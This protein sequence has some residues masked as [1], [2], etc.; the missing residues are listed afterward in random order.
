MSEPRAD[1][2]PRQQPPPGATPPRA[3]N[4]AEGAERHWRSGLTPVTFVLSLLVA[5]FL[6]QVQLM[7]VLLILAIV[8][9][10]LIERPVELLQSRH[11]P[12]PLSILIMY[13]AI[14]AGLGLFFVGVAPAIREQGVIFREE[15][16]AQIQSLQEGWAVSPNPLLNGVGQDALVRV[17]QFI[18][19][20][21]TEISVPEGAAD[22][23]LSLATGVGGGVIGLLTTLVIAFYYLMEK[24][25]LRQIILDQLKPGARGRIAQIFDNVE[26]KVGDWMRGQLV[27]MLVIGVSATIGYGILGVRFWPLLGIW[28]GLTEIIPIVGPWLGGIPAVI[29]ALTQGWDKALV[30]I[31]FIV[32]LQSFE[33]YILVPR[34]MRGAVGLSP[35]TVFLAI[36]AGT[37]FLGILGAVLAIP[38]AAAVQVV[39]SDYFRSRREE[40][41][42]ETPAALTSWQ[43]MR[44]PRIAGAEGPGM[45][46]MADEPAAPSRR[47]QRTP[48]TQA[49]R[50]NWNRNV[51]SRPAKPDAEE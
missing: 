48:R 19:A 13:I 9:A 21:G 4:G 45:A 17:I 37:Q 15:A 40:Y 44:G 35:M 1:R 33:N 5:Y 22:M 8:F 20:P 42:A 30:V 28:A 34:V 16:P 51:L 39:L 29:I 46:L 12:R 38:I 3:G 7:L 49:K 26:T 36:L 11:L 47:E 27:L 25:W 43:W 23:V 2:H 31:G 10:T 32:L 50:R 6:L 14:I 24:D 41:L 18:D